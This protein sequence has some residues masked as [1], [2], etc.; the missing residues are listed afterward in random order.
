MDD[1]VEE[2]VAAIAIVTLEPVAAEQAV[3]FGVADDGFDNRAAS[4]SPIERSPFD[5]SVRVRQAE[6]LRK[7]RADRERELPVV[8]RNFAGLLEARRI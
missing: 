7:V 1:A 8:Y 6:R 2:A 3:A 5:Q 4:Q